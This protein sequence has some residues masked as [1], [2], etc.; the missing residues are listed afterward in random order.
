MLGSAAI[1]SALE[2]AGAS[3]SLGRCLVR[4]PFG[5]E[6]LWSKSLVR[7]IQGTQVRIASIEHL[8]AMKRVAG[9]P[10]D[11]D[12]IAALEQ[13]SRELDRYESGS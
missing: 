9:R 7:E 13:I 4:E 10:R 5:F 12:D 2:L 3:W 6:A 1:L 8:I 11:L